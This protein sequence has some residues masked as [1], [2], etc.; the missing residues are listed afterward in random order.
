MAHTLITLKLC[1]N[2]VQLLMASKC[3]NPY[4]LC[5]RA[6]ISY[7]SYRRIMQT[8]SC[9]LSTL[10]KIANALEVDVEEILEGRE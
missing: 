3:M 4:D 6:G 10:G 8:G 1:P 7:P 9:K 5:S 2:R